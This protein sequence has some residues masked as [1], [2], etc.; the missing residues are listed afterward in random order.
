[1]MQPHGCLKSDNLH[2][3]TAECTF[4]S[5]TNGTFSRIEHVLDNK[6]N[7]NKFKENK[8]ILISFLT[9]VE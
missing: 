5:S 1:M 4:F 6:T 7:L 8:I 2:P 9:T 3:T